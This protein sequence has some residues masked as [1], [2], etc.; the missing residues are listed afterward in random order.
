MTPL[1]A[2]TNPESEPENNNCRLDL[3]R[4][5]P[6]RKMMIFIALLAGVIFFFISDPF[7]SPPD[8]AFYWAWGEAFFSRQNFDL[9]PAIS[10]LKIPLQYIW[11]T[12]ANRLA[13]DWPLGSGIIMGPF[14][15]AGK[16][17][18]QAW[19]ILIT[20]CSIIAWRRLS[21]IFQVQ[22]FGK[23]FFPY[24]VTGLI[25]GT[26]LFF[27]SLSGPFFS[28]NVSF[29]FITLFLLAWERSLFRPT[30]TNR[31]LLGLLLGWCILI[32][33]QN[34]LLAAIFLIDLFV[35]KPWSNPRPAW[36]S[37]LFT[38]VAGLAAL[39]T[40]T[41]R[42]IAMNTMYGNPFF[43]PKL[44]EMRW[45]NPAVFETLFSDY[46]GIIPWTPIYIL[47][48]L[49]LVWGVI[50][51]PQPATS[52]EPEFHSRHVAA[53]LLLVFAIQF[54]INAAN[55]VW[56]SGG[57]FGNRR[58]LDVSIVVAYGLMFLGTI[59]GR[60]ASAALRGFILIC[61]VWTLLLFIAERRMLVPLDRYSDFSTKEF[62]NAFP[63]LFIRYDLTIASLTRGLSGNVAIR[64]VSAIVLSLLISIILI[65][66]HK[67][68]AKKIVVLLSG[69]TVIVTVLAGI[70]AMRTP[71]IQVAE[72]RNPYRR[73]PAVLWD[74][75]MELSE[76]YRIK[77]DWDS[78]LPVAEKAVEMRPE[79][80]GSLFYKS[81]ALLR[82]GNE[83]ESLAVARGILK[84]V[85]DH[86]GAN[87]IVNLLKD[88]PNLR[89]GSNA[90][91][92][93]EK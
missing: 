69:C 49:G 51:N 71:K 60:T 13:N 31:V 10:E 59:K 82:T 15:W 24:A 46:H 44:D 66:C 58:M 81:L 54:Y 53:G 91:G 43:M 84:I 8:C 27:Y 90:E 38:A 76:Y 65:K 77:Q 42:F 4:S 35:V 52:G 89:D 23:N 79:Q 30:V 75:Y 45:G 40:L 56:W 41:P 68:S 85:P 16:T 88:E 63:Q 12:P 36:R 80:P 72:T 5:C 74:N 20:F 33:P 86:K 34:G 3:T 47:G 83:K 78:L 50:R 9:R 92:K 18:V 17:V 55:E 11:L 22:S 64:L 2:D 70:S 25:L 21:G 19:V 29:V 7:L 61:S 6:S 37:I 39:I 1:S 57:S 73:E 48:I 32:R 93:T 28:H 67:I 14:L 26:P 62:W 87:A